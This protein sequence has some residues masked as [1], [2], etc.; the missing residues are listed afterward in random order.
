MRTASRS[1]RS[2]HAGS[3][4]REHNGGSPAFP[5]SPLVAVTSTVRAPAAAHFI[6][7]PTPEKLSSS[8][9]AKTKRS[10]GLSGIRHEHANDA[11]ALVQ[12][13]DLAVGP[14]AETHVGARRGLLALLDVA[15]LDQLEQR[16]TAAAVIQKD[17]AD[18]IL[19]ALRKVVG[20]DVE[21]LAARDVAEDQKVRQ[22]L[23]RRLPVHRAHRHR[24]LRLKEWIRL[25]VLDDR[26][27]DFRVAARV[28]ALD[29][30]PAEILEAALPDVPSE[31]APGGNQVDFLDDVL[32]DVGEEHV[33]VLRIP[34]EALRVAQAV[35]VDF[36]ERVR[37]LVRGEDVPR[38][39]PV[40]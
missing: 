31:V 13:E 22:L 33:A 19:S 30:L 26:K 20:A 18:R 12:Q 38:R 9:W 21:E 11:V 6:A 34:R 7:V 37:I 5:C 15:G 14:D 2:R 1:S 39:N 8:G 24:R 36:S 29:A 40:L 23:D 28:R 10:V 16:L 25:S 17:A 3:S 27:R 32:A 35:S 4:S